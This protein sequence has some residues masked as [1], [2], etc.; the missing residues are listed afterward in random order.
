MFRLSNRRHAS[1]ASLLLTAMFIALAALPSQAVVR[2]IHMPMQIIFPLN[3]AEYLVD[4]VSHP[5]DATSFADSGRTFVP[6]RYLGKAMG[7]NDADIIWNPSLQEIV[8]NGPMAQVVMHLD[9]DVMMV[10]GNPLQMDVSPRVMN[11][12]TYL[13]ARFVVEA[14][15]YYTRYDAAAQLVYIYR[16]QNVSISIDETGASPTLSYANAGDTLVFTNLGSNNHSL[17]WSN[18]PIFADLSPGS[19]CQQP[20]EQAGTFVLLVDGGSHSATIIVN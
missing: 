1:A 10:D 8:L 20:M 18:G 2:L 3:Q 4:Q 7:L 13:P 6:V 16:P 17:A 9:S 19:F 11:G 14:N 5:M 12:R 15:G